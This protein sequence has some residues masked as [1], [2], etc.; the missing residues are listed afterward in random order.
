[1]LGGRYYPMGVFTP[2]YPTEVNLGSYAYA[3]CSEVFCTIL[4]CCTHVA[5]ATSDEAQ[6]GE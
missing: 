4:F 2:V 6:V 5:S 3:N 1:M